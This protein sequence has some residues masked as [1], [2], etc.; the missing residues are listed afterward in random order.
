MYKRGAGRWLAGRA[1][2]DDNGEHFVT[3]IFCFVH[4]V[5]TGY[6]NN[7]FYV[8]SVSF[9]CVSICAHTPLFSYISSLNSLTRARAF[10]LHLELFMESVFL[11]IIPITVH[12]Q[13]FSRGNGFLSFFL[14]ARN[15]RGFEWGFS[16]A[17]AIIG[18]FTLCLFC[19]LNSSR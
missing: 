1:E 6:F 10:G 9:L 5:L 19:V 16:S 15:F 14:L 4:I 3:L 13:L 11:L 12:F 7:L 17:D 8:C 2:G 18:C